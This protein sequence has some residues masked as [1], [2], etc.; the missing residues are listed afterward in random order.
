MC[1][2]CLVEVEKGTRGGGEVCAMRRGCA[3]PTATGVVRIELVCLLRR[4]EPRET[5]SAGYRQWAVMSRTVKPESRPWHL[6]ER[7]GNVCGTCIRAYFP[8]DYDGALRL[9]FGL[10]TEAV[11]GRHEKRWCLP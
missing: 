8:A 9:C 6:F 4:A 3:V 7:R 1:W 2:F 5:M 11:G 10:W